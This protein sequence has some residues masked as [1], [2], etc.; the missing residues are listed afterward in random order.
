MRYDPF[1]EWTALSPTTRLVLRALA[2]SADED[3]ITSPSVQAI[4]DAVGVAR[5]TTRD[6]I[7]RLIDEG[8]VRILIPGSRGVRMVLALDGSVLDARRAL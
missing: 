5:H 8:L 7:A 1:V 2:V 6:A 4:A 3:G